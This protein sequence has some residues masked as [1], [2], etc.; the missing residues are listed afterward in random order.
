LE[1]ASITTEKVGSD[2]A[3]VTVRYDVRNFQLTEQT[4]HDH[5][6]AN[7]HLCTISGYSNEVYYLRIKKQCDNVSVM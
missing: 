5:H 7:S 6:M 4:E 3:K 1:I 2:S